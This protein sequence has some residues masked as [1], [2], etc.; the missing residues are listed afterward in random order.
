M[1]QKVNLKGAVSVFGWEFLCEWMG[2]MCSPPKWSSHSGGGACND[3][4][5]DYL[6]DSFIRPI[7][8][9]RGVKIDF[10]TYDF[11]MYVSIWYNVGIYDNRFCNVWLD[12]RQ[13]DTGI[14]IPPRGHHGRLFTSK[15][16]CSAW[17]CFVCVQFMLAL[18]NKVCNPNSSIHLQPWLY[19][20]PYK[21]G[22]R[23][24]GTTPPSKRNPLSNMLT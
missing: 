6:C 22:Q 23:C 3:F 24:M 13:G 19:T 1:I 2:L 7:T 12:H 11:S 4:P 20:W 21:T 5:A 16:H 15:P 18:L 9:V 10:C 14:I 17:V 8:P